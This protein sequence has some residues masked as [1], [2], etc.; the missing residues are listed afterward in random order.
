MKSIVIPL[1]M[2]AM[3]GCVQFKPRPLDALK[4]ADALENRTL[5]DSGL[6]QYIETNLHR[7][8]PSWPPPA[9]D[10]ETLTFAAFYFSSDLAVA[11]ANYDAIAA[12]TITAAQRPNPTLGVSP[13][14]NTT[15]SVPSPWLVT[16]TLDLPIETAGKRGHR[17]AQA[18]HLSDAAG[19]ALA[20][21]AWD[22]RARLRRTLID[23]WSAQETV[24]LLQQQQSAQEDIVRLL[25]KEFAAGG[26]SQAEVT[27]ERIAREQARL[28]LLDAES[29]RAQAR[30]QLAG[31]ISVPTRALDDAVISFEFFNQAPDPLPA[32]GARRRALLNRTDIFGALA[33]YAAA[34]SA[35]RLEIAK[36][37]P[38]LHLSPG[39]EFDQGDNKWGVGLS[40]ELP[41]LNHN[42]G[43]IAEAEARRHESAAKFNALQARVLSEV[44]IA[45][46]GCNN[47][48][49]KLAA[50]ETILEE[51]GKHERATLE[52]FKAGEVSGQAVAAARLERATAA[53]AQF[54]ARLKAQ[55][56]FAVLEGAL[57]TPLELPA[58][59]VAPTT[60]R[61]FRP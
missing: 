45:L 5:A 10:L 46:A 30:A 33:Q 53:L 2:I 23:L 16:A 32:D 31:V 19:F 51:S 56:A 13:A 42:R 4:Q 26:I 21:A 38:D 44:E 35:L 61:S 8:F 20:T 7:S 60:D 12:G 52:M 36:Q 24:S 50:A 47:A 58:P 55:Q 39:Y 28:A 15:A 29:R 25:E 40:L 57:Q 49:Q 41:I 27:R 34:E 9:W 6:R 17:I 1:A 22:V 14:Y 37:Y 54:D 18:R 3:A 11:R 59:L 43:P 48:R